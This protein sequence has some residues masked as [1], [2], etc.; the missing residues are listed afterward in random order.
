MEFHHGGRVADKST[1]PRGV[2]V[3][4]QA[5]EPKK[6]DRGSQGRVRKSQFEVVPEIRSILSCLAQGS[7]V[8]V[9][10]GGGT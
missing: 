4:C 5:L 8:W 10:L 7:R 3:F 1:V 2:C 9:L 6:R